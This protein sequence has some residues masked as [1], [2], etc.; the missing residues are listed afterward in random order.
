MGCRRIAE[1]GKGGEAMPFIILNYFEPGYS[2]IAIVTDDEGD[3]QFF[4][5]K[6]EAR[7]YAEIELNF[8]WLVVEI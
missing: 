7:N 6:E 8:S 2:G 4:D 1:G 5:S 3:P